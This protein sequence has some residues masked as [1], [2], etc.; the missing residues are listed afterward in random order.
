VRSPWCLALLLAI[1]RPA[2][3]SAAAEPPLAAVARDLV[4]SDQGVF[5]Q[6][7]DGT[8][9][10]ALNAG[11]AVHPASVTKLATTLALLRRLGPGYR[12]ETR[13]LG[14]GPI[15]GGTLQGDLVVRAG[16][17]PVLLFENA[18]LILRRLRG[19]GVRQ[20]AGDLQ[21]RGPLLFNWQPDPQ[22]RRLRRALEGLD[23]AGAWGALSPVRLDGAGGGGL[24]DVAISFGG[25]RLRVAASAVRPLLVHRSPPLQRILKA[26]NC[27]SNNVFHLLSEQIGGPAVVERIARE[28]VPSEMGPEIT[29]DNAAG[30]GTTNRLSPR[31]TVALLRAL[32]RELA[33]AA[34]SLVDVLP[35]AGVDPGTLRLRLD[36]APERAAVVGK[37]GTFGSVGASALA[38]VVRTRRYGHVTFAVLNRGLPVLEAQHRQDAFVRALLEQSEPLAWPYQASATAAF[39]EAQIEAGG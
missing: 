4:G 5:A 15:R 39:E 24:G 1:A 17:D 11:R 27:Y 34:L 28:S 13:L 38:G 36:G 32:E 31:A 19:L 7:E 22:G 29:I 8:V 23:G 9:L 3:S 26:L 21:V 18:F 37:T 16:R 30:A 25:R 20:V 2:P 6:A 33:R 10:A 35:V 14:A 12:F